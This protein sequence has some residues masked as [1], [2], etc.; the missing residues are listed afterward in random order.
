MNDTGKTNVAEYFIPTSGD[1]VK[2]PPHRIPVHYHAEVEQE[3]STMLQQG[4]IEVSSS[5]WMTP[6][7]FVRKK[8]GKI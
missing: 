3:L 7:V 4:V 2:I 8:T 5:L 1:T 6:A